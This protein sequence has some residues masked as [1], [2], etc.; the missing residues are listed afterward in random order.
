MLKSKNAKPETEEKQTPD[1]QDD[2]I[3]NS[4]ESEQ[5]NKPAPE[6]V[7]VKNKAGEEFIVS[8]A[9]FKANKASLTLVK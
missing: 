1:Q 5:E 9:Y 2:V 4:V 7:K 3:E 6:P 8:D